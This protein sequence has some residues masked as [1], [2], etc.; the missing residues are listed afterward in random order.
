MQV[1]AGHFNS[2]AAEKANLG[3]YVGHKYRILNN[4]TAHKTHLQIN[5]MQNFLQKMDHWDN[6]TPRVN[7]R[8]V[9]CYNHM[10]DFM[11]ADWSK[12]GFIGIVSSAVREIVSALRTVKIAMNPYYRDWRRLFF[13]WIGMFLLPVMLILWVFVFNCGKVINQDNCSIT[14]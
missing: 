9:K 11:W 14:N 1:N 4:G 10:L 5:L 12:V 7:T 6:G 13:P 8:T 3:K 2:G